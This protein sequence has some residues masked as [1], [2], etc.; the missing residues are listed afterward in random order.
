M[1]VDFNIDGLVRGDF[2]YDIQRRK[3]VVIIAV[4]S[5]GYA[6]V[7]DGDFWYQI[8]CDKLRRIEEVM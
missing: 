1:Y 8:P 6:L 7:D 2:V 4:D 5:R 3:E